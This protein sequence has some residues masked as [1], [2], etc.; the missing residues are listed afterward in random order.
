[1]I[2]IL[3]LLFVIVLI[4]STGLYL[5]IFSLIWDYINTMNSDYLSYIP[6]E[7]RLGML[8]VFLAVAIAFVKSFIH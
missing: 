8:L 7:I 2:K 4:F 5:G 3:L 1:M 6:L